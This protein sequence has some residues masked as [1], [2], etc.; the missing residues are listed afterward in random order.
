MIEKT[1]ILFVDDEN[2]FLDGLKRSLR[3]YNQQ[4]N[5]HFA[6]ST[7]EALE[8][9][10]RL[11]FDA[12]ISDV[13]MPGRDGF[14]LLQDLQKEKS[15]RHIPVVIL[16]GNNESGLKR[17]ALELGATDLL[18]KPVIGEDLVARIRSVLKIKFYQDKLKQQ[19]ELLEKRVQQRT[20]DLE[21]MNQDILWRLA[22]A[23][24]FR[25]EDTGNH[26]TRVALFS[27][28]I[29][30][31]I[32]LSQQEIDIIYLTAPL[33]DVGKIGISDTILLKPGPL[34]AAERKVMENHCTIGASILMDSPKGIQSF[35]S[36]E[37][38]TEKCE[39]VIK[40]GAI[41]RVAVCIAMHH[42][43]WWNG[44]GYPHGLAGENI[45]LPARIVAL[46]DTYD[47]LCSKRPYKEGFSHA[48]ACEIIG[49]ESGTHFD[50]YLVKM[51]MENEEMFA[52]IRLML[53]D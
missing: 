20:A 35:Q 17:H 24:E 41:R 48:M 12:I 23:A 6:R 7:D 2:H 21:L 30:Q 52:E 42:H 19:N 10:S 3:S 47:A 37:G 50:P 45:E 18:N 27:K 15:T 34:N 9:T 16:T 40:H 22:K 51:F 43:E 31:K 44:S 5:L 26:I 28:I 53:S 32:G 36:A 14:E 29:A 39:A 25:D 33:H 13:Q 8:K 11:A 1:N 38:V 49:S 46:A 4:W